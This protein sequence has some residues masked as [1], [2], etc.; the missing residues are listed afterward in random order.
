VTRPTI[1]EFCR[2]WRVRNLCVFGSVLADGF[3]DDSDLDVLVS[4]EPEA[5]WSLFDLVTMKDELSA[6]V[7]RS[8]D[9]IEHEVL[10]GSRNYLRRAAIFRDARTVYSAR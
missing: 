1:A 3:R 4:F 9:L 2:R 10:E 7:G 6:L 8:V 5:G